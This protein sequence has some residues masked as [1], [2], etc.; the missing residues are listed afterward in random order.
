MRRQRRRSHKQ[1]SQ[2]S[3]SNKS[4]AHRHPPA[5]LFFLPGSNH[6]AL[7][8][9]TTRP[10][11]VQREFMAA[12]SPST[13]T[14]T[15]RADPERWNAM[16]RLISAA[17]AL[18]L[19][20]TTAAIARPWEGGHHGGYHYRHDGYRHHGDGAAAALGIGLGLFALAAIA[21]SHD[22]DRDYDRRYYDA[23]PPPPPPP[24]YRGW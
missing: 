13:M 11:S 5:E 21:A 17:L 20:G 14:G 7:P 12:A 23:P 15:S 24:P 9:A 1:A 3:S 10:Y 6:T 2:K 18:S 4:I 19:L 22:R 16:K 8:I